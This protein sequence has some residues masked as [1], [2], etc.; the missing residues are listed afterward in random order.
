MEYFAP[1]TEYTAVDIETPGTGKGALCSIG[2]VHVKYGKIIE[3]AEHLVNP[4]SDFTEFCVGIHH[5]TPGMVANAPAFY[6]LWPDIARF[7]TDKPLVAHNAIFDIS[8][9]SAALVRYGIAFPPMR[10]ICTC[11]LARKH[12][13]REEVLNHRLNTLCDKF[14]IQLINHHNALA[15]AIAA[16][17]LFEIL[18][19]KFGSDERDIK[20]Y[21][22][23][24]QPK[25]KAEVSNG[26]IVEA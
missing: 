22:P 26:I 13:S 8:I 23:K 20:I 2:L 17:E 7:F 10:Y 19:D 15:D 9:I 25:K 18:T 11:R 5:I 3:T 14:D 4:E 12:V 1:I 21:S 16:Q 24:K 6:E